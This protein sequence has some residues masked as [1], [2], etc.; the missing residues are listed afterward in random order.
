MANACVLMGAGVPHNRV[1]GATTD[2]GMG[3]RL[4]DPQTG[5]AVSSG[6]EIVTPTRIVA[7][8]LQSAG[9]DTEDL[10]TEG[11]PCLMA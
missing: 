7:S 6:G 1:V 4:V 10:R 2:V 5:E 3:P 8:V 11:L 9:Y